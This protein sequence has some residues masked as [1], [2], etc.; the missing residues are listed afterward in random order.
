MQYCFRFP[1]KNFFL[2]LFFWIWVETH[3]ALK[4]LSNYLYQVAMQFKSRDI[5]IMDT[6]N[7]DVSS[8]NNLAFENNPS[9]KSLI[10]I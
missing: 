9:D 7:K 4:R 5:A 6:E 8:A 10:G 1:T 2:C 3:F